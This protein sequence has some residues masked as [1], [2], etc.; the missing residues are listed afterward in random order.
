MAQ[1]PLAG[2][3]TIIDDRHRLDKLTESAKYKVES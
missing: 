3:A 2:A 1:N